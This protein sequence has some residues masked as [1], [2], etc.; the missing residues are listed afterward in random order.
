MSIRFLLITS[1]Y[2]L[3][4]YFENHPLFSFIF[5][6]MHYFVLVYCIDFNL[7][8]GQLQKL[9]DKIWKTLSGMNI[10]VS[11]CMQ[12]KS[13]F[14]LSNGQFLILSPATYPLIFTH[15]LSCFSRCLLLWSLCHHHLCQC[16]SGGDRKPDASLPVRLQTKLHSSRLPVSSAVHHREPSLHRKPFP[17]GVRSQILPVQRCSAQL[18]FSHLHS[19]RKS[20]VREL[21]R[22]DSQAGS[23]L[24]IKNL[25]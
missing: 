16:R 2:Y 25:T 22:E 5:I 12:Q 1:Q 19:G 13:F 4:K 14:L 8:Y 24:K 15:F 3:N 23:I 9:C 18:L 20:N 11:H 10:F 21:L 7:I 6:I 17:G